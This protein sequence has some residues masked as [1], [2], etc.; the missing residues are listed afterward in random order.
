MWV[1]N[2]HRIAT[3]SKCG[4]I[5]RSGEQLRLLLLSPSHPPFQALTWNA[6]PEITKTKASMASKFPLLFSFPSGH[7]S[8]CQCEGEGISACLSLAQSEMELNECLGAAFSRMT[9]FSS[10]SSAFTPSF[11]HLTTSYDRLFVNRSDHEDVCLFDASIG[12]G[13]VLV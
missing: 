12:M 2:A 4:F 9:R 10:R 6:E 1:D 5:A 3:C 11:S 8:S 13:R 7:L